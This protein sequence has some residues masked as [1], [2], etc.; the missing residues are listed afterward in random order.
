MAKQHRYTA[1]YGQ[2]NLA[3]QLPHLQFQ[4]DLDKF[5]QK[6]IN[7]FYDNYHKNLTHKDTSLGSAKP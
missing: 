3:D 2:A 5:Q 1:W 6:K 4:Y 7:I